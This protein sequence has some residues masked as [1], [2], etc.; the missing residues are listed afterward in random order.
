[1][2]KKQNIKVFINYR[3]M[4]SADLAVLLKNSINKAFADKGEDIVFLDV[5]S[6]DTG[7]TWPPVI[8]EALEKA[9]VFLALIGPGWFDVKFDKSEQ[10]PYPKK[11]LKDSND[12]VR[13]EISRALEK[14]QEGD[15]FVILPLR[16]KKDEYPPKEDIDEYLPPELHPFYDLS[17]H[18][19]REDGIGFVEDLNAFLDKIGSYLNKKQYKTQQVETKERLPLPEK[20]HNPQSD[21]PFI[22]L[23]PFN[24]ADCALFF[25][26][27]RDIIKLRGI[28]KSAPLVL[29]TGQSGA[30]KS[31]LLD[32]GLLPR[33]EEQ[34]RLSDLPQR[35]D[36]SQGLHLQLKAMLEQVPP[37]DA[38]PSLYILDQ[39]EE[40]YT[41]DP[42]DKE[43]EALVS[44]IA[45][46]LQKY[47]AVRIVL[48]YRKEFQLEITGLFRNLHPEIYTLETLGRDGLLEACRSVSSDLSLRKAFYF[49]F[50]FEVPQIGSLELPQLIVADVLRDTNSSH[51]A[52]LLQVQMTK[53]WKM[54][55]AER[56]NNF[57]DVIFTNELYQRIKLNSL[58]ELL[59]EQLIQLDEYDSGKWRDS[60]LVLD[61]LFCHTTKQ[62]TA[63][64]QLF[65]DLSQRYDEK[66]LT[67]VLPALTRLYLLND[68]QIEQRKA[69][70]LAHDSLA[71]LVIDLFLNSEASGQRAHR[72]LEAKRKDIPP[73]NY[74]DAQRRL[75][76]SPADLDIV[77]AGLE[78]MAK[79]DTAVLQQMDYDRRTYAAQS[80]QRYHLAM[81]EAREALENFQ[82]DACLQGLRLAVQEAE[83]E[84]DAVQQLTLELAWHLQQSR[85]AEAF[86]AVANFWKELVPDA[87]EL[88]FASFNQQLIRHWPDLWKQ[89]E[90]RYLPNLIALKKGSFK[91]GSTEG[92]QDEQPVH[93]VT[94]SAY[95]L[96]DTPVTWWQYGLYCRENGLE[97]PNDSGFGKG[98][99]PIINF[100][101][102]DAILYCNWL[103]Q[104]QGL[105]PAY[106]WKEEGA[107]YP[108]CDWKASGYRLPTEAEWEFAAAR[109][110]GK[111]V[112]FGN[113]KNEAKV[114]EMNFDAESAYNTQDWVQKGKSRFKTTSVYA[115]PPNALGLYDLSGNVWERCW[116]VWSESDYY[117]QS[118]GATDPHGPETGDLGIRVVRGGSWYSF[119]SNCRAS[120]RNWDHIEYRN[121]DVGF[122]LARS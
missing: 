61:I 29:L 51:C 99:K 93:K 54:A 13:N 62:G 63:G 66:I 59:L 60:G 115:F 111:K 58:Q 5:D 52:P 107:Q 114:D 109:E 45:E 42:I 22:G 8:R 48:G 87:P 23:K 117:T 6:I 120:C 57:D 78:G 32:A 65:T 49:N 103:S 88:D 25:G 44:L 34:F 84:L 81:R 24:R 17:F 67:I 4:L 92:Y 56:K 85:K 110:R 64:S 75:V 7:E 39:V 38:K 116:D 16:Y 53:M 33:L 21:A 101:W 95:Q 98:D 106:T 102:K 97:L 2:Q 26:R 86:Q 72:I 14:A 28:V 119:A 46:T 12:W 43:P 96:A 35:R 11:R 40:M 100:T 82:P 10:Q 77:A 121:S 112:R 105:T 37:D 47:K 31:S 3:Q 18:T 36:K 41:N 73:T 91:M 30:G 68:E 122:R 90:F 55:K 71:P 83:Q 20:Y 79:T 89:L 70:R 104:W 118:K 19:L 74:Q 9:Q 1:M 15:N 108:D 94:L 76:F 50:R 69:T 113:G 80:R 27:D